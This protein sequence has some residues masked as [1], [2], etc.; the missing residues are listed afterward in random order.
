MSDVRCY[1]FYKQQH[2]TNEHDLLLD[3]FSFVVG[4]IRAL[5]QGISNQ[6]VLEN[7]SFELNLHSIF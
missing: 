3:L 2:F 1:C 4:Y 7:Q 6:Y 5:M